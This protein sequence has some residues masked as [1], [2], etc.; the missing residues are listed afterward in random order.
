METVDLGLPSGTLWAEMN[1]GAEKI[2]DIGGYVAFGNASIH[3]EAEINEYTLFASD[4]HDNGLVKNNMICKYTPG[5]SLMV[6]Q[7]EDDMARITLGKSFSTPTIEDFKELVD[8]TT[9]AV[10]TFN[11][12][13][14]LKLK[15]KVNDA[16]LYF[17][18]T[19]WAS[20]GTVKCKDDGGVY[21]TANMTDN[22]MALWVFTFD[23]DNAQTQLLDCARRYV[24]LTIRAICK[25]SN[26]ES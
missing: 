24:G 6:M 19:G 22:F 2:S 11:N 10:G 7:P 16:E 5:D 9:Q 21:M 20:D 18:C 14:C 3:D 8:N 4:C 17:P 26:T 15:S 1:V 12:E 23:V 25:N 13:K